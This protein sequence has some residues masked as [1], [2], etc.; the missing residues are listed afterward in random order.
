MYKNHVW[1]YDFLQERLHNGKKIRL[2]TV[3]DEYT[4]GGIGRIVPKRRGI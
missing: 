3:I 4:R 1:S 2:L